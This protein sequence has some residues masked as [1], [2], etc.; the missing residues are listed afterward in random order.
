MWSQHG[1]PSEQA[2]L[3]YATDLTEFLILCGVVLKHVFEKYNSFL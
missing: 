3:Y 1:N 2:N